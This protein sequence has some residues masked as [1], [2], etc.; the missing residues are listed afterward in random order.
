MSN[1]DPVDGTV[2]TKRRR[3]N[4]T[5]TCAKTARKPFGDLP[6]KDLP[7]PALTYLYNIEM[8]AVDRGD[9]RRAAYQIQQRQQKGWKAM[10]YTL[11]GIVVVNSYLLSSYAAVPK[12]EKFTKHLAYRETLYKALFAQAT[13]AVA[14]GAQETL[15]VAGPVNAVLPPGGSIPWV[16]R[17][18][19][20]AAAKNAARTA[21]KTGELLTATAATAATAAAR[22][23]HQRGP[24]PKRSACVM[25]K[26]DAVE[27]RR[28]MRG[29]QRRVLHALSANIVS[30]SLDRHI[31]RPRTG[32][33][34]CNVA[35][36]TTGGCWEV[37]HSAVKR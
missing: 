35:L 16:D 13:G 33:I 29:P 10:F 28:G 24:L 2:T 7:R 27:G 18:A 1:M 8:N 11:V 30:R 19:E 23:E 22:V 34:S 15:P 5:A 37:F 17:D 26:E 4:E 20:E 32:Y 25:C 9:Q 12:K 36:C 3:P 21:Y 14:A 31:S 6:E